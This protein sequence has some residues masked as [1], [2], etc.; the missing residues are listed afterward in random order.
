MARNHRNRTDR[1]KKIGILFGQER[2]FPYALIDRINAAG[3]SGVTAEAVQV[4]GISLETP[5]KYDL[6]LDRISQDI[7]FYRA[8]LKQLVSDGTIVVNNPFSWSA[9]AKFFNNV[10]ARGL[11]VAVPKTV[12]LP[13]N[14]HP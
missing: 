13:S 6:I 14:Q 2:S 5:R 3:V 12:L 11:G 8:V 7:P 1:M 10:I 4:G 9:D